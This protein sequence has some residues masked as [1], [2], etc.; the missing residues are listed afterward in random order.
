VSSTG[1]QPSLKY[2]QCYV[3]RMRCVSM[4]GNA[5][6]IVFSRYTDLFEWSASAE[7]FHILENI[8]ITGRN[9]R[10]ILFSSFSLSH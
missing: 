4:N 9:F 3:D 1:Y 7:L 8:Q 2:L 5:K 10:W 6:Q